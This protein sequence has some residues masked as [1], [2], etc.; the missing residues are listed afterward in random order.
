MNQNGSGPHGIDIDRVIDHGILRPSNAHVAQLPPIFSAPPLP[1]Y[2]QLSPELE[3]EAQ[4]AGTFM[5]EYAEF[6]TKASPMTPAELHRAAALAV[7]STAIARRLHFRVGATKIYPNLYT[8]FVGESTL[9]RKT[10]GLGVLTGLMEQAEMNPTFT[11][12]ERQTPEAFTEDL[13]LSIPRTYDGWSERAKEA[14][15]KR[16]SFAAQRG[17][18]LD[19][20]SH[21][22]D[23][24]N[25]DYSSG[26]LPLVLDMYDAKDAPSERNTRGSGQEIVEKS[27]L[28]ILGCTTHAAMAEHMQKAVH[29]RNGFF[30]RFALVT[31][32]EQTDW[33]F[34]SEA[35]DYPDRIIQAVRHVAFHLL[36]APPLAQFIGGS[37]DNEENDGKNKARRIGV[38][39]LVDNTARLEAGVWAIWE[40]YSKAVSYDMLR[41]AKDDGTVEEL[42]FANY[43]RFPT[44]MMKV[45]MILATM[46]ADSLP[47]TVYQRHMAAAQQI[48]EAW[49]ESLH[50]VRVGGRI[51]AGK[52]KGDEIRTV[53][54][55]NDYNLTTR[56]DLL[57][58]MNCAWSEIEQVIKDLEA[59]GEIEVTAY[60]PQRGPK[61][62]RYRLLRDDEKTE[63]YDSFRIAHGSDSSSPPVHE[64]TV[65]LS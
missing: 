10:T 15:L 64:E 5:H 9:H 63:A 65:I 42:L 58:A 49:R 53:L 7:I 30:A 18:F 3:R 27:Y 50:W 62:E 21:L 35:I 31:A 29:W 23:S 61:S 14:W 57:R 43:G 8:L 6:A 34:W 25:R 56:R 37:D 46:D 52:T 54:A 12:A 32:K 41:A 47:I 33:Q 55:Q 22:L 24:F 19:E 11:L 38:T 20:A 51:S 2:A 1:D 39:P 45:A 17:W 13:S 59:A 16:R 44:M 28:T 48:V 36:G 40:R 26:L 4:D 60:Q